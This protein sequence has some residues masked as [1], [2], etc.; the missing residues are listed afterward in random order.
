[1]ML[2][3]FFLLFETSAKPPDFPNM[4]GVDTD[5]EIKNEHSKT[6]DELLVHNP[7]LQP[8]L[9]EMEKALTAFRVREKIIRTEVELSEQPPEIEQFWDIKCKSIL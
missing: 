8:F 6:G 5:H 3:L 9:E 7:E 2:I 1:M 4:E